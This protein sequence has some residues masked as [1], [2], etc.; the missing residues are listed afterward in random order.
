MS[1]FSGCK[2]Q[3]RK[4]IM[5]NHVPQKTCRRFGGTSGISAY[6]M[7]KLKAIGF[8]ASTS[9]SLE[10]PQL[11]GAIQ[12]LSY[13]RSYG[14]TSGNKKMALENPRT[15]W[16]F[17]EGQILYKRCSM[18]RVDTN[19]IETWKYMEISHPGR[20]F[21]SFGGPNICFRRF[22]KKIHEFLGSSLEVASQPLTL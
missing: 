2:A 3:C 22:A 5:F 10:N 6:I 8:V 14:I 18:A 1:A 11:C 12:L 15:K 20:T 7:F 19:V 21:R 13:S 17:F 9:S 16:R 4:V